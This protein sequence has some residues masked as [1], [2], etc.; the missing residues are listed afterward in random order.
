[1]KTTLEIPD[2]TFRKAKARAAQLGM[3]LRE[4]VTQAVDEKLKMRENPSPRPWM[5]FAGALADIRH[6]A[7]R[8]AQVVEEEFE[9]IEPEDM[10]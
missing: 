9:K 5:K 6:E 8:I 1:M 4:Y 2:P 10:A 3:P 7:R